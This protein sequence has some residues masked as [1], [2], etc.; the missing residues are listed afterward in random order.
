MYTEGDN[1]TELC[2][3]PSI[4]RRT[5][6]NSKAKRQLAIWCSRR[7]PTQYL[8]LQETNIALSPPFT[9]SFFGKHVKVLTRMNSVIVFFYLV[10]RWFLRCHTQPARIGVHVRGLPNWPENKAKWEDKYCTYRDFLPAN[11]SWTILA[12][13][14]KCFVYIAFSLSQSVQFTKSQPLTLQKCRLHSTKGTL[15][16]VNNF[17]VNNKL[18]STGVPKG[19][20]KAFPKWMLF[21]RDNST[22]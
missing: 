6:K 7:L 17:L 21:S 15:H 20:G 2:S 5:G 10:Y 14:W 12:L 3:G 9:Y 11:H 16:V 1:K 4:C 13:L 8:N 22:L 18:L 19:G